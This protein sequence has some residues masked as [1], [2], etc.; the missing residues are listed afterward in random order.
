MNKKKDTVSKVLRLP[1]EIN[2]KVGM[3]VKHLRSEGEKIKIPD[4]IVR[5]LKPEALDEIRP[6]KLDDEMYVIKSLV[7]IPKHIHVKI[8]KYATQYSL[9]DEMYII[10]LLNKKVNE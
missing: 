6:F 8:K 3:K 4:L 9:S 5:M 1:I 7:H 10:N 2:A